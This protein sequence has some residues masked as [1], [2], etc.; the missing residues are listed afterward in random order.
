MF[1]LAPGGRK[2]LDGV[3]NL[4]DRSR[5]T[6]ASLIAHGGTKITIHGFTG[7]VAVDLIEAGA[8]ALLQRSGVTRTAVA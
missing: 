7:T 2:V 8:G 6:P 1:E 5:W 4:E 3:L